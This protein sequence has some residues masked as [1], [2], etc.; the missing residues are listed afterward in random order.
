M[1]N[2]PAARMNAFD[3]MPADERELA[4]EYG[5]NVVGL[6][7]GMGAKGEALRAACERHRANK[8]SETLVPLR[9]NPARFMGRG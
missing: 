5:V 9:I 7:R 6:Y 4:N 8:Q 1:A 3:H 2:N